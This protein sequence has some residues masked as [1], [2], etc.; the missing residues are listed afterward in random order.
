MTILVTGG[1][2]TLGRPTVRRLRA[3]GADVRVLSRRAGADRVRGDLDTG[4]GVAAALRGADTVVHLATTSRRDAGQTRVLLYACR[5]ARVGHLVFISIVG[6]ERIPYGYYR[7]KVAS[8]G[9][10]AASGVPFTIQRATQFHDFVAAFLRLQRRLPA[11]VVPDLP[12][13]PIAV[14]E[15][16]ARLVEL[17]TARPAG[18]VAD[19]GGPEQLPARTLARQWQAAHGVRE[20]TWTV[21]APGRIAATFRAGH[22]MTP[23]PGY[24]RET[25]ARW[26]A[27]EAESAAARAAPAAP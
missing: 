27:R 25:F 15:V 2:G 3:T 22:H 18:R 12:V 24:G 11:I 19:I 16:A 7:D 1:T 6:V 23:L 5:D 4:E 13:Q 9:M 26:A 17:A 20:R 21:H 8:E 14:E 10:I